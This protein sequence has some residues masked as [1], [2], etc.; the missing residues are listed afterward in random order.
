MRH[1]W[2]MLCVAALG[3][4]GCAVEVGSDADDSDVALDETAQTLTP[5]EPVRLL[6]AKTDVTCV[7]FTSQG[8]CENSLAQATLRG[9]IEV[10]NLAF[11][12][13]VAVHYQSQS[14]A[15]VDAPASFVSVT[16]NNHEV[17]SF[18]TQPKTFQDRLG[19][20]FAFAIRYTVAGRTF[21]DNNSGRDYRVGAG[22]RP[23]SFAPSVLLE[24]SNVTLLDAAW[25]APTNRASG[26][27]ALKNLAFQKDVKIVYSTDA[28]TTVKSASA[29]FL[30][31]STGYE[32]W[33]FDIP[34]AAADR[35]ID[36]AISYTVGGQTYW[37]NNFGRN[38]VL[39]K[40][41]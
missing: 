6:W 8:T 30:F 38:Y 21:W 31:S 18:Q 27:I 14:G 33:S 13:V 1:A 41:L 39:T 32:N 40:P 25:Q 19:T 2:T 15:W 17:W 9:F 16:G 23:A 28:W 7:Q 3:L 37:D 20:D 4:M 10:D 34:L 26:V 29:S 5:G 11:Q 24:V 35:R 12:K 22:P 36:F